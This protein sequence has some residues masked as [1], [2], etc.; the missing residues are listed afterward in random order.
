MNDKSFKLKISLSKQTWKKRTSLVRLIKI[1]TDAKV[2]IRFI[3][4]FVRNS[5]LGLPITDID[6]ATPLLPNKTVELL[7]TAGIDYILPGVKYGTVTAKIKG[8]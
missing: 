7:K 3:G 2:D 6:L 4:G 1:F 8:D 5:L